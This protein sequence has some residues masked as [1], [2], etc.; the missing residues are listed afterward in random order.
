MLQ[1][2]MPPELLTNPATRSGLFHCGQR[3]RGAKAD[4]A[5]SL[6]VPAV[7]QCSNKK[8]HTFEALPSGFNTQL[9]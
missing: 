4:F 8:E 6:K 1:N 7:L 2:R 3:W 5:R 9:A